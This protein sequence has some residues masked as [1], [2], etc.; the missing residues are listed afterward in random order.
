MSYA[1]GSVTFEED[2]KK[3]GWSRTIE[4]KD[5]I[6]YKRLQNLAAFTFFIPGIPVIYYADEIGDIG[7]GDPD[8]RRMM[9]FENLSSHESQTREVFSWLANYRK[10]NISLLYGET[11]FLYQDNEG[12]VLSRNYF[13][14]EEVLLVNNSN[15]QKEFKIQLSPNMTSKYLKNQGDLLVL[16]PCSFNLLSNH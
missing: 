4:L 13:G 14:E 8:N 3:A 9:R 10:H 7:A 16:E 15:Q 6:A 1:D 11:R 2:P 12:F 5:T